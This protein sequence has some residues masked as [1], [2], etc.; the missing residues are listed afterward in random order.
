MFYI[1]IE[2]S[3]RD[4]SNKWSHIGFSEDMGNIDIKMRTL[5]TA[6]YGEYYGFAKTTVHCRSKGTMMSLNFMYKER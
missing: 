5:S 1:I 4:N 6:L 3:R 2:T